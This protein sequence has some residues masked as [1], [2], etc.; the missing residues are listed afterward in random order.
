[1]SAKKWILILGCLALQSQVAM[2]QGSG[3][4]FPSYQELHDSLGLTFSQDA[5]ADTITIK[6]WMPE[7]IKTK[8]II[9]PQPNSPN[10][11]ATHDKK[12]VALVFKVQP[13]TTLT[14]DLFKT[15]ETYAGDHQSTTP[16]F[17]RAGEPT[18]SMPATIPCRRIEI[19]L[20]AS[21]IATELNLAN[22]KQFAVGALSLLEN[23][24]VSFD[25]RG[26]INFF[27]ANAKLLFDT[28]RQF[29]S[30][31]RQLEKTGDL[32]KVDASIEALQELVGQVD[33]SGLSDEDKAE[34]HAVFEKH[35]E[36]L[37]QIR[38]TKQEAAEAKA[39][40]E[41]LAASTA[42]EI[43]N[44]GALM[45]RL[46]ALLAKH[47]DKRSEILLAQKA[48][49]EKWTA[50]GDSEVV[51]KAVLAWAPQALSVKGENEA[52]A[53]FADVDKMIRRPVAKIKDAEGIR[54]AA[55]AVLESNFVGGL[56]DEQQKTF[57][58]TVTWMATRSGEKTEGTASEKA[59]AS[60]DL[61]DLAKDSFSNEAAAKQLAIYR[62][63]EVTAEE[64]KAMGEELLNPN[65]MAQMM[66]GMNNP[67]MG[68]MGMNPSQAA[69]WFMQM[70]QAKFLMGRLQYCGMGMQ[71]PG[72]TNASKTDAA[73]CRQVTQAANSFYTMNNPINMYDTMLRQSMGGAVNE[74]QQQF[75][76]PRQPQQGA[77]GQPLASQAAGQQRGIAGTDPSVMGTPNFNPH[78]RAKRMIQVAPDA[79]AVTLPELNTLSMDGT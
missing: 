62:D 42:E 47:S 37:V 57:V 72:M 71:V 18:T 41:A 69:K 16:D 40:E 35:E 61:A 67:M 10:L 51:L 30:T 50:K 25:P 33:E 78:P 73:A 27:N 36:R 34:A 24:K 53:S 5:S 76:Q 28:D 55:E 11:T 60:R 45:K 3:T 29:T 75:F 19:T 58:K 66:M 65:N 52:V 77:Q 21:Q 31:C 4:R 7:S 23:N 9:S 79:Q 38:D 32:E 2:A 22:K 15:C 63:Y 12:D 8:F 14:R 64:G 1:M 39:L 74:N 6:Y 17:L 44:P 70:N 43:K 54:S 26:A 59:K 68:G 56:S 48:V 13:N 20:I 46:N 49:L